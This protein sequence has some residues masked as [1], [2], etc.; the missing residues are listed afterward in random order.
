[1]I[2]GVFE[3]GGSLML[4]RNVV[5]LY[6]DK[7][8]KGVRLESTA[9]FALWGLWNLFYY[10]HLSQ[11]WSFTGGLSITVAN[12]VW[13]SQM[14]YYARQQKRNAVALRERQS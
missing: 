2:N 14:V 4:W 9:F 6:R 10:P 1:M 11:W 13:V 8:F 12:C 5:A 3:F 7:V